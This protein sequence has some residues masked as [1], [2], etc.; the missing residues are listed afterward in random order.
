MPNWA[1]EFEK[2]CPDIKVVCLIA[3]KPYRD[4]I[5]QNELK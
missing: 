2:W 4:E 5:L 1:A 3:A